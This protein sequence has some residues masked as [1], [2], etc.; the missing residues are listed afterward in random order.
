MSFV[1]IVD[2]DRGNREVL[3]RV[4]DRGG[5]A[6][7]SAA[8]GR[9]GIR[10]ARTCAPRLMLAELRLPDMTG[11]ELLRELRAAD[12]LMPVVMM[13]ANGSTASA[14]EAMKLGASDYLEKPIDVDHLL[15]MVVSI[16]GARLAPRDTGA[17]RGARGQPMNPRVYK[18]VEMLN[19]RFQEPGLTLDALARDI[20][21]TPEHLCRLLRQYTGSGFTAQLRRARVTAARQLLGGTMLSAKEIAYKV[22]FRSVSRFNRDFKRLCGVPPTAYRRAAITRG[23]RR[24]P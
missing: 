10:L 15:A 2:D 13:T 9:E 3:A 6:V 18:T 11:L 20:G 16:G 24:A 7:T 21:V 12:H 22:G 5:I 1:L 23:G 8:T 4:L 17:G 19:L 14:V